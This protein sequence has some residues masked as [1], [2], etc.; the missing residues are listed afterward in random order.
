MTGPKPGFLLNNVEEKVQLDRLE[1]IKNKFIAVS[2][3]KE[4][5]ALIGNSYI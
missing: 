3:Q 2:F 1:D 5:V 4:E